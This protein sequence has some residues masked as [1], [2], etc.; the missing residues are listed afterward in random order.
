MFAIFVVTFDDSAS[1]S[2]GM[3]HAA[4]WKV[5]YKVSFFWKSFMQWFHLVRR[6]NLIG[7]HQPAYG[8]SG[9]T[10]KLWHCLCCLMVDVV[11]S[12]VVQ[13]QRLACPFSFV[14][15]D[16]VMK[17]CVCVCVKVT[18]VSSFGKANYTEA[19]AYYVTSL[20]SFMLK[21]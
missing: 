1:Q 17:L 5:A 14:L 13:Q 11:H 6:L 3:A 4:M 16:F 15:L 7:S 18:F 19:M 21:T 8:R 2:C 12:I 20:A 9:K 10:M